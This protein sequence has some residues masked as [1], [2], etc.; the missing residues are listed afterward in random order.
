MAE[1]A[2]QL[3]SLGEGFYVTPKHDLVIIERELLEAIGIK[4]RHLSDEEWHMI[5]STVLSSLQEDEP[6]FE[7]GCVY[8]LVREERNGCSA[9]PVLIRIMEK[10]GAMS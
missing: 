3:T 9:E 1:Y 10:R 7:V 8:G 5:A 4:D 6:E 2:G